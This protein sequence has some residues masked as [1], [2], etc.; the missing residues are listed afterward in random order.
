MRTN[1]SFGIQFISRRKGKTVDS[2][3]YGRITVNKKRV[4]ISLKKTVRTKH[5]D[6]AKGKLKSHAPDYNEFNTHL[7]FVQSKLVEC[8]QE[9]Q[10]KREQ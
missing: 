1:Q 6:A 3:V 9:L 4:E 5:W 2:L 8:Y 10:L 7:E